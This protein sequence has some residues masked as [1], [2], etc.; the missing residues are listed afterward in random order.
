MPLIMR[1]LKNKAVLLLLVAVVA[2]AFMPH[3]A[4]AAET[5][6]KG[7]EV[8]QQLAKLL[9]IAMQ[10]LNAL[11]WPVLIIIGDLMKTDLI[12]GPAMESTLKAIWVPVRDLVNIGFVVVLLAVAFYN[13]LGIGGG[14]GD[15]ALKT[16]LPKII[17][18]LVIVNFT[19]VAGKVVIDLTNVATTAVFALPELAAEAGDDTQYDFSAVTTKFKINVCYKKF[20]E[21]TGKHDSWDADVPDDVKKL[22]IYTKLFCTK[23]TTDG[24]YDEL[25]GVLAARY[26]TDLNANNIGLVMAVNMGGLSNLG[27]LKE[28]GIENF[29]D[30]TVSFVF[31]VVMYAVFAV[32]YIVLGLVL[33]TRL[34][35]LWI[36]LALSPLAVLTYVVPQIKEMTGGAGD[37]AQKV[38]KHLIAPIIIGATMSLGYILISAW[39]GLAGNSALSIGGFEADQVISTEFL[40]NGI[41]DLPHFIIAI[42]SIVIVWT[43]V[44]AAAN[45]TYASVFTKGIEEFGGKVKD[46]AFKL[47]MAIPTVPIGVNADGTEQKMSIGA[48]KMMGGSMMDGVLHDSWNQKQISDLKAS[49]ATIFG[50]PIPGGENQNPLA[51]AANLIDESKNADI[52]YARANTMAKNLI[53]MVNGS[54][55]LTGGAKT[56]LL[57]DIKIVQQSFEKGTATDLNAFTDIITAHSAE[58]LGFQKTADKQTV[59]DNLGGKTLRRANAPGSGTP[60]PTPTPVPATTVIA[61][62]NTQITAPAVTGALSPITTAAPTLPAGTAATGAT[63]LVTQMGLAQSAV[64]TLN[65]TH[66]P[67]DLTRAKAAVDAA[68]ATAG[69]LRTDA[70]LTPALQGNVVALHAQL[71][72]MKAKLDPITLP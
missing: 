7:E 42:A 60:T 27:I 3:V 64:S 40:I 30:L 51:N 63:N 32:S 4:L 50:M 36:A 22:P 70:G 55:S 25:N 2:V 15:L 10:F 67:A 24:T 71:T 59:S 16:A 45:D 41:K 38:V 54:S 29:T 43:G 69:P 37:F 48:L 46:F 44:F 33:I 9:S 62:L 26:F 13:V 11:L 19:F 18:G 49:G 58:D 20:Y 31:A 23:S 1:F 5:A 57:D 39:D 68:L 14:E 34:V 12:L 21:D 65:T 8:A 53:A 66:T 52:D 35:V 47:P 17:I 72:D 28:E 56:R 6:D 61:N